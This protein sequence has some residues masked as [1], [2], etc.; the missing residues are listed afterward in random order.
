Q[1]VRRLRRRP[2]R[3]LPT[4]RAGEQGHP[5]R[6]DVPA[7]RGAGSERPRLPVAL[8]DVEAH[9]ADTGRLDDDRVAGGDA[10]DAGRA[11]GG[12]AAA[13]AQRHVDNDGVA[14]DVADGVLGRH[15]ARRAADDEGDLALV[16]EAAV[17]VVA[18]WQ[19]DRVLWPRDRARTLHEEAQRLGGVLAAAAA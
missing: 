5:A 9:A 12:V 13:R 1:P 14:E 8:D 4:L 10:A 19:R 6:T 2:A 15:A 18:R 17:R 3:A 16:V 11:A 7:L